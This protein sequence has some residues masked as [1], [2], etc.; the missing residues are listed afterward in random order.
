[1]DL[2]T[3]TVVA[4]EALAR[5]Q[6]PTRGLLE[7]AEFLPLAEESDLIIDLDLAILAR[8]VRQLR[9]W[10]STHPDLRL[11]PV[12]GAQRA[13]SL[14]SSST[15]SSQSRP[16]RSAGPTPRGGRGPAACG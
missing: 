13:E 8:A 7:P 3:D 16:P 2:Q 6:H 4:F 1:V 15:T 5:W 9:D 14:R 12:C 10:R 11:T